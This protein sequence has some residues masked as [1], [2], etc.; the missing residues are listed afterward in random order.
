MENKILALLILIAIIFISTSGLIIWQTG[1][2]IKDSN[3]GYKNNLRLV[4]QEDNNQIAIGDLKDDT[5]ITGNAIKIS[6]DSKTSFISRSSGGG[7][8]SS[9]GSSSSDREKENNA[10]SEGEQQETYLVDISIDSYSGKKDEE[11][12][13]NV[14][15]NTDKKLYAV[16][17]ELDYNSS[18]LE[19]SKDNITKGDFLNKDGTDTYEI[20]KTEEGKIIF[21][22]TRLGQT[23]GVSGEGILAQI[24]F[25][26]IS[27][28]VSPLSLTNVKITDTSLEVD[29]FKVNVENGK[30]T[31]F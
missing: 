25:K 16:E 26:A 31:I 21:A 24:K 30:V 4:G 27:E 14:Y 2:T 7:G 15:I 6:T 9:G 8:G 28:G 1:F 3:E 17:F 20:I 11:F 13:I 10:A 12:I 29:K 18:I 23:G 5:K 19:T 22:S